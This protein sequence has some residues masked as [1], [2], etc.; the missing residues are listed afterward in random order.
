M[1]NEQRYRDNIEALKKRGKDQKAEII[2]DIFL[3]Y[4]DE[5][6]GPMLLSQVQ[7]QAWEKME[8]GLYAKTTLANTRRTLY[9]SDNGSYGF[10]KHSKR[11]VKNYLEMTTLGQEFNEW[12]FTEG[13]SWGN[14]TETPTRGP[15]AKL[16]VEPMIYDNGYPRDIELHKTGKLIWALVPADVKVGWVGINEDTG[17]KELK[18]IPRASER[19]V[20]ADTMTRE[21]KLAAKLREMGMDP[22]EV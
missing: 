20:Q 7:S 5:E 6:E 17:K 8:K 12:L 11:G 2:R 3:G 15:L 10:F 18:P 14:L 4:P 9:D 19:Q 13:K 22:D 21:E 16:P 1:D